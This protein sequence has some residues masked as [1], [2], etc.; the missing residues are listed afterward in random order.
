M[1]PG[2]WFLRYSLYFVGEQQ[3]KKKNLNTVLE[4]WKQEKAKTVKEK[5]RKRE[6]NYIKL[7]ISHVEN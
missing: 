1:K 6:K 5:Q 7:L 2:V 3:M 4:N